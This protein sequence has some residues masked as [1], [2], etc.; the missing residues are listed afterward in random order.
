MTRINRG[1]LRAIT[2]LELLFVIVI[3]G[4]LSSV[5]IGG[6]R[7]AFGRFQLENSA[8]ELASLMNFL[9]QRAIVERRAIYLNI[10]SR[11]NSCQALEKVYNLPRGLSISSDIEGNRIVFY[12]DGSIDDSTVTL[13]QDSGEAVNLTTRGVLGGVKIQS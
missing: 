4:I 3:I 13:R 1:Y 8:G 12:P 11:A 5:A 7:K 2:F 6:F 10:D 9:S